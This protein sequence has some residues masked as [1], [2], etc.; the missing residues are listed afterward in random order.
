MISAVTGEPSECDCGVLS[1]EQIEQDAWGDPSAGETRLVRTA[2]KLRRK[3]VATLTP[4]D[5]RLLI[6]QKISLA[7]LVPRALALL[8]SDPLVEGDFYPGD[9]LVAVMRLPLEYWAA[10]PGQAATLREIASAVKDP[11][12]GIQGDIES[13]LSVIEQ[14]T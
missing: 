2:H 1:L 11:D 4:E 14:R 12:S 5:F 13:F 10:H 7:V 6:G 8:A 9:L 3:P